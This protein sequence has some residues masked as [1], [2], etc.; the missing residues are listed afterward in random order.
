MTLKYNNVAPGED[1]PNRE[2]KLGG[3]I[4]KLYLNFSIID[5]EELLSVD[6][7]MVLFKGRYVPLM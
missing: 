6:D 7:I 4:R 5:C 2:W 3:W 1:K